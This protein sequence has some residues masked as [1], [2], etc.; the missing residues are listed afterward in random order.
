MHIARISSNNH[1][2]NLSVQQNPKK[3]NQVYRDKSI[4][5]SRIDQNKINGPPVRPPEKTD[6]NGPSVRPP[7]LTDINGPPTRP[8]EITDINGPPIRPPELTDINGPPERPPE[9]TDINGPPTRPLEQTDINGP[10]KRPDYSLRSI[11]NLYMKN[12]QFT[13]SKIDIV[14]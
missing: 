5:A 4:F 11:I 10:P 6:I 9:L 13:E 1:Y 12:Y 2:R 3:S 14:S 8:L 7:E